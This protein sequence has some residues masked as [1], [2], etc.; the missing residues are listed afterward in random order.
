M[1]IRGNLDIHELVQIA[2]IYFNAR[3]YYFTRCWNFF[4]FVGIGHPQ[5]MI[6]PQKKNLLLIILAI[7]DTFDEQVISFLDKLK[8]HCHCHLYCTYNIYCTTE[9]VRE[10]YLIRVIK[11][12]GCNICI[13][14]Y[15]KL[16]IFTVAMQYS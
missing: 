16:H 11:F 12:L 10:I 9:K 6:A 15:I 13:L 4:F 8:M 1:E 3:H 5:M 2:G 7:L 14:Q